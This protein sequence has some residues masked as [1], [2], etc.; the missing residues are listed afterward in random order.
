M[1]ELKFT[2]TSGECR[3]EMMALLGVTTAHASVQGAEA[4]LAG[5]QRGEMGAGS[6]MTA[7]EAVAAE[8]VQPA[9]KPQ[10]RRRAA[11]PQTIEGD[12]T[13]KTETP[14][15]ISTQPENRT[16]PET[17]AQDKADEAVDGPKDNT[18]EGVRAQANAY[19]AKFSFEHACVD[20]VPCLM[21]AAGVGT[22]KELT[23]LNDPAKF[24]AATVA[25]RAA[26][27]SDTRY[28]TEA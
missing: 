9:D 11:A 22:L 10:R 24:E 2:G 3:A 19:I 27:A 20:L 15:N 16:D 8:T 5:A 28:P 4:L 18:V 23:A 13:S 25:I 12:V 6:G 7:T 21:K 14:A 26:V 17:A 1:I